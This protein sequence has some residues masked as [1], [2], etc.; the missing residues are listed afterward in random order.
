MRTCHTLPAFG[1]KTYWVRASTLHLLLVR[2]P[3][4]N[5]QSCRPLGHCCC[6]SA[7]GAAALLPLQDQEQYLVMG[8]NYCTTPMLN[9]LPRTNWALR[10]GRV[11]GNGHRA[12]WFNFS[13]TCACVYVYKFMHMCMYYIN[14]Y[15]CIT[16]VYTFVKK[17]CSLRQFCFQTI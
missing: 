8:K 11:E 6:I 10:F 9:L 2:H 1:S 14:I 16:N 5:I 4:R 7:R 13:C 15:L 3:G 12:H 17:N